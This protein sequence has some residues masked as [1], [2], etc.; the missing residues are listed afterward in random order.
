MTF[1]ASPRPAGNPIEGHGC[2]SAQ[3]LE[4]GLVEWPFKLYA[5]RMP[6]DP[7]DSAFH[8][9]DAVEFHPHPLA[10]ARPLDKLDFAALG[11]C[12]EDLDTKRP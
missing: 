3:T 2:S 8:G 11:R 7:A 12:I 1:A 4:N 5:A 9:F 10:D 6:C